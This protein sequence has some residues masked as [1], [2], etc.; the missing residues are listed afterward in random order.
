MSQPIESVAATAATPGQAQVFCAVLRAQGIPA[1]VEGDL[2]ADEWAVSRRL[3]NLLGTRVMVPT[4]SLAAAREL[5][6]PAS[7]SLEDLTA[8]ALAAP[9]PPAHA[10]T[11]GSA[12]PHSRGVMWIT[13]LLS[14]LLI[15]LVWQLIA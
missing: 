6:Q 3:M 10:S 15:A 12:A 9:M 1:R 14:A 11:L 7:I 8:Q 4:E 2:L 13:L 5:L